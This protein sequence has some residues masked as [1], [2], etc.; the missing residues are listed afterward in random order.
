M[1][2]F[3]IELNELPGTTLNLDPYID[4]KG[5]KVLLKCKTIIYV[6]ELQEDMA[7]Y[8]EPFKHIENI[9]KILLEIRKSSIPKFMIFFHKNDVEIGLPKEKKLGLNNIK[10][11]YIREIRKNIIDIANN[12]LQKDSSI[13]DFSTSLIIVNQYS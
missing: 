7:S 8:E 1:G 4:E 2:T 12:V 11:D 13:Y 3:N 6:M 10:I 5:K 9:F